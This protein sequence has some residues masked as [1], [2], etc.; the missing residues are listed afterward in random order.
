[1]KKAFRWGCVILSVVTVCAWAFLLIGAKQPW[2]AIDVTGTS[3]Y[4]AEANP[5]EKQIEKDAA[6]AV[7]AEPASPGDG[8]RM[9]DSMVLQQEQ[10]Q[11][12]PEIH[13]TA[14]MLFMGPGPVAAKS[15]HHRAKKSSETDAHSPEEKT[16]KPDDVVPASADN[17]QA[18]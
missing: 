8:D 15:R 13:K 10:Q 3:N 7:K 14:G 4:L 1:M 18:I 11:E 6:L 5:N 17:A 12:S 2:K 16:D 9:L